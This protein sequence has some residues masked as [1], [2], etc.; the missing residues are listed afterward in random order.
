MLH[1]T[2]RNAQ[3]PTCAT[4]KFVYHG[5]YLIIWQSSGHARARSSCC[6]WI[7]LREILQETMVFTIKY[8]GFPVNF[9]IIQFYDAV[10]TCIFMI[11]FCF[12][13]TSFRF[14]PLPEKRAQTQP[15]W[16]AGRLR[17]HKSGPKRRYDSLEHRQQ[18]HNWRTNKT[19]TTWLCLK[20]VYPYT[21]WLMIIIPTKWL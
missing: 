17:N 6:Q 15:L 19:H 20:I 16:M 2:C 14:P 7:G 11:S 9:P 12:S 4:D 13:S 8:R 21:Q 18:V 5:F 1:G 3:D 10:K